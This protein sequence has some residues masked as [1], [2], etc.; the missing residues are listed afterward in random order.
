MALMREAVCQTSPIQLANTLACYIW[1]E[2]D[3]VVRL[4]YA[5]VYAPLLLPLSFHHTRMFSLHLHIPI[6]TGVVYLHDDG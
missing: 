1:Y 3:R 4:D 5:Q 6:P 2:S